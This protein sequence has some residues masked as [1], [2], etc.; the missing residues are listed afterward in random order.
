MRL[1]EGDDLLL[2]VQTSVDSILPTLNPPGQNFIESEVQKLVS[3]MSG[4]KSQLDST[5]AMNEKH[6]SLWCQF[7]L[8]CSE[9]A[10]WIASQS[11]ELQT[12]PQKRTGLQDKKAALDVQQVRIPF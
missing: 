11:N 10:D 8:E 9:F 12:E 5:L 6:Y 3:S 7:D 2:S 1:V 4:L